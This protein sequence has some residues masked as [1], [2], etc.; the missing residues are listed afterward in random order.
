MLKFSLTNAR[1]RSYVQIIEEETENYVKSWNDKGQQGM[2]MIAII[3]HSNEFHLY[4]Y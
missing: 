3:M 1:F 4:V 2:V